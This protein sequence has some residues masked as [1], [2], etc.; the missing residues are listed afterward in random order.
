MW[1]LA[2]A[3]KPRLA[4]SAQTKINILVQRFIGF[5]DIN[6]D[7]NL[8]HNQGKLYKNVWGKLFSDRIFLFLTS[9]R[10]GRP[11]TVVKTKI[12]QD[13]LNLVL[14]NNLLFHNGTVVGMLDY[15][16]DVNCLFA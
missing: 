16:N 15:T 13:I 11:R 7:T 9:A 3:D 12:G 5:S 14:I 6:T 8:G 2:R 4:L 10:R 1:N